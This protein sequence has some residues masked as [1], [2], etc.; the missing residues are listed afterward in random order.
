MGFAGTVLA[1][2]SLSACCMT[3]QEKLKTGSK[4]M[5]LLNFS[6]ALDALNHHWLIEKMTCYRANPVVIKNY[7]FYQT[8]Y[9]EQS[10]TR[11]GLYLT[12]FVLFINDIV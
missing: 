2:S 5:R 1:P 9:S 4:Y 3:S 6:R 8:K 10:L 12:L 7:P 11:E